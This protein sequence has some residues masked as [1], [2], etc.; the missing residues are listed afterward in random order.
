MGRE[1]RG[2]TGRVRSD[3][4]QKF[5]DLI[6]ATLNVVNRSRCFCAFRYN[7]ADNLKC[8]IV[9]SKATGVVLCIA[10]VATEVVNLE[11][12]E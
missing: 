12:G 4:W 5:F 7:A 8:G 2:R 10:E 9:V 3:G 1:T 11:R 6:T